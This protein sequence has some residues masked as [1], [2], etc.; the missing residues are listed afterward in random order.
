MGGSSRN[1]AQ[2]ILGH[3]FAREIA[4]FACLSVYPPESLSEW[5]D[6]AKGRAS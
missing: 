5:M 4:E 3:I 2:R 6:V 1:I